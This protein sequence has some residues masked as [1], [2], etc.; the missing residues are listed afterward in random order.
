MLNVIKKIQVKKDDK[1]ATRLKKAQLDIESL[2][3]G[4]LGLLHSQYYNGISADKLLGISIPTF[5]IEIDRIIETEM[6]NR[7]MQTAYEFRRRNLV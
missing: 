4:E 7:D 2:S 3:N 5:L 1:L 6:H